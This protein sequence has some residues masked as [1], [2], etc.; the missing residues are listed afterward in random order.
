MKKFFLLVLI[1]ALALSVLSACGEKES[2]KQT[3]APKSSIV[4][5][6]NHSPDSV[7]I[8]LARY[9]LPYA[10]IRPE[11]ASA[12]NV[13][14]DKDNVQFWLKNAETFH[15]GTYLSKIYDA[16]L[17]LSDDR[18]VYRGGELLAGDKQ[19]LTREDVSS[20]AE[21]FGFVYKGKSV[22]LTV[23][24]QPEQFPDTG[25]TILQVSFVFEP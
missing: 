6:P 16:L 11:D 21:R 8:R 10:A 23:T 14:G 9:G 2:G 18:A 24:V 20:Q 17:G 19:K 7:D 15:A 4:G 25:E 13:L 1:A 22:C 5:N 3:S 12:E